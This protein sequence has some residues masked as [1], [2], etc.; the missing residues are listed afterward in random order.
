MNKKILFG[1]VVLFLCLMGGG[2]FYCWQNQADVRALNKTLPEGVKVVK[3]LIGNDYRVVNKIDGYEFNIP[4]EWKGMKIV[5]Y[6]SER[7]EEKYVGASINLEGKEGEAVIL[8][9][10]RFKIS[11]EINNLLTWANDFFHTFA[12]VGD[13]SE[14]KIGEF[15]IVKTQENVHLAGMYVYFFKKGSAIYALT[16]GSE[17]FIRYIIVNGKW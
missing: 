17:E 3:S 11:N 2:L 10:D 9:I 8:S 14:D 16:S 4:P 7:V 12:L 15:S 1:A 6:T 13:F 5:E